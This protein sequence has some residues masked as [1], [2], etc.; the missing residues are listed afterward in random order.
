MSIISWIKRKI[1]RDPRER[2]NYQY[3]KGQWDGLKGDFERERQEVVRDYFIRYKNGGSLLEI[4]AGDGILPELIFKKNHYSTYVGADIADEVMA[5]AQN[6]LGDNRH[7]FIFGDMNNWQ[8]QGKY[9]VILFNEAINYAQNLDKTLK[10][11]LNSLNDGGVFIVSMHEHK[12]SPEIWTAF[13]RH[14]IV[15]EQKLVQNEFSKW[16]VKV[17]KPK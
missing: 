2:W 12:R 3:A 6:R 17:A 15:L 14:F 8:I 11:A 5:K 13:D 4:G 9:D 16:M 10:D 1:L 7:S